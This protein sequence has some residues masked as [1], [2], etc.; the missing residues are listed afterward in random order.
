MVLRRLLEAQNALAAYGPKPGGRLPD[1]VKFNFDEWKRRG[2]YCGGPLI[3]TWALRRADVVRVVLK[4]E[5][6][7]A[8]HHQNRGALLSRTKTAVNPQ[9]VVT[10]EVQFVGG[11]EARWTVVG[12]EPQEGTGT[13]DGEQFWTVQRW[14]MERDMGTGAGQR[15]RASDIDFAPGFDFVAAESAFRDDDGDD[16]LSREP[17][18]GSLS[19]LGE[20]KNTPKHLGNL[21]EWAD[22]RL[23]I[24]GSFW[25]A[26]PTTYNEG[27]MRQLLRS[28][29]DDGRLTSSQTASAISGCS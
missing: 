6:V 20:R 24:A 12:P 9:R 13:A 23:A 19:D 18:F 15:F 8:E 14:D 4:H 26:V 22:Q 16:P 3:G 10:S 29:I 25:I 27:A 2:Q 21:V 5:G 17:S 28:E 11:H 7:A 1:I